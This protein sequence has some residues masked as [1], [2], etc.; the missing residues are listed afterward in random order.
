MAVRRQLYQI[1]SE[2][3]L[4]TVQREIATFHDDQ[5]TVFLLPPN[6]VEIPARVL[7][8]ERTS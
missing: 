1:S 3:S 2:R 8:Y 5:L 6:L 4:R 7:D